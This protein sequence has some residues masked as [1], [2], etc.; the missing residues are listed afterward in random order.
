M[1]PARRN[2][3]PQSSPNFVDFGQELTQSDPAVN[4]LLQ[5]TEQ[6]HQEA[7]LSPKER[8]RKKKSARKSVPGVRFIPPT[9]YR[10][11]ARAH[12]RTGRGSRR[13][14]QPGRH[15][16]FA[17]LC[18]RPRPRKGRPLTPTKPRRAARATI[19]TWCCRWRNSRPPSANHPA[20]DE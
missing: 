5:R 18:G 1:S 3:P 17:A 7:R 12:Q 6:R 16:R 13:T 14:R 4:L 9:T 19:S 10:G 8:E 2:I 20:A 11:T 15:A